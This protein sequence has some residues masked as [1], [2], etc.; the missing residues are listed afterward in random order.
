MKKIFSHPEPAENEAGP[1]YWRSLDEVANTPGFRE[2]L[3]H[4]FPEGASRIDG[5]DRRNFIKIMAAS[6]ALAGVG[7]AGCR[8]PERK[9]LPFSQ[10]PEQLIPGVAAF[11]ATAMPLRQHA[12]PLLAE[13]HE[14]RPTKLE[15]NPSYAR[16]RGKSDLQSQASVLDLYDP[17]R[18][19]HHRLGDQTSSREDVFRVLESIASRYQNNGG[20]GLAF[21]AEQSSS[22]TRR[23][24]VESLKQRFPEATWAEY[25]PL[26]ESSADRAASRLVGQSVRAYYHPEKASRIVALESDLVNATNGRLYYAQSFARGRRL[27]TPQEDMNRLYAVESDLSV[28]GGMADHRLRLSSTYLP[29]FIACLAVEVL[30]ALGRGSELIP[31]LREASSGLEQS[32]G[33]TE[34]RIESWISEC[35]KDLVANQGKSLIVAGTHL[36]EEVQSLVF[37]LN[38]ALGNEG[39]TFEFLQIEELQAASIQ[40][41]AAAVGRG[42]V[43]TLFVLGGNP[44]HNA[45]ADL[46]W[47]DLQ[48]S[49]GEV[50]RYGYYDDETSEIAQH[51]IAATHFL[52]AWGDAR[53]LEGLVVSVQPMIQPLFGGINLLEVLAVFTDQKEREG[54]ALVRR[55]VTEIGGGGEATFRK[56]LHDGLLEG[57]EFSRVSSEFDPARLRRILADL[58]GAPTVLSQD[59]LEVRFVRDNRIDDGRFVNNGWLQECPDPISKLTW[60]NAIM[61]SP[62][63]ADE[64]GLLG[65]LAAVQVARRNHN[66]IDGGRQMAPVVRVTV[67]GRTLEGPVH[68][69]PGLANYS[70]ILPLGY[71]RTRTGRIGNGSGFNASELRTSDHFFVATGARVERTGKTSQLANAQEHWSLEGRAIVREANL[72]HYRQEPA[73]AAKMGMESHAPPNLG[74]DVDMPLQQQ[75]LEQ[76]RGMSAYEHPERGGVN[77]WG[78][79]ID[80]NTCTGCSACVVACQAENNI[81]IVGKDQVLRGREMHWMRLDRYFASGDADNSAVA[82]DPQLVNQPML[83]Q[84][85]ENAPC[86][87]VCPVNATVHDSEG[88]NVMV[89]NRCIGTRYCANNC[90]YKVRRFNFFDWQERDI[91]KVYLGPLAPKGMSETL[92]MQKN[93][94]VT[95][96]MRGVMEKCTFC[97]QRITQAKIDQKVKAGAS[98]DV[99]VR[100]G[101]FETACQQACPTESIIFGNIMDPDSEVTKLKKSDRNYSVLGYLNTR[102]RLTYL[103]KVRNPNVRMPDYATQPLTTVEYQQKNYPPGFKDAKAEGGQY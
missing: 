71:G 97:T 16:A 60:E 96:R 30:T 43:Q 52:E 2:Y 4:E 34:K 26:D 69:Q 20:A 23:S 33:W 37:A 12:L 3:E 91:N 84:H 35:A 77:Q 87:V 10:Q 17:D 101:S 38:Q 40:D 74:F 70:L 103:A 67:N 41:L 49:I 31:S 48:R 8:R 66:Q 95:V 76:P 94:N 42:Q 93:P 54:Y 11:Y 45:P 99:L 88:L 79:V 6:F 58:N 46:N 55:T 29:A 83:C 65:Q 44:V 14:G 53:T 72:E 32:D 57:S 100:D 28:T 19:I 13:T 56:F 47:G 22:P 92:K 85:C 89:Y 102:P 18:S 7:L 62:R 63:L 21:L 27:A 98:G 5:V 80:L 59:N 68:V 50:V 81:P 86:E 24:L 1:S 90:P 36:P 61:M 39:E 82:E 75:V 15:G 78:M 51:H 9:I 73:F 25:E 64:L